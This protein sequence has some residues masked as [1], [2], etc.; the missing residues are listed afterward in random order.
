M[1][2]D[3]GLKITVQVTFN[4]TTSLQNSKKKL[5]TGSKVIR[6]DNTDRINTICPIFV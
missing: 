5:L 2:D 1:D 3:T 4:G 6:A